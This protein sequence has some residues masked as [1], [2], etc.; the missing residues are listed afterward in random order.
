MLDTLF[1]LSINLTYWLQGLGPWLTPVMRFFTFLGNEEFYLFVMPVIAWVIDYDLGVRV[2]VMLLLTSN[3]NE[4]L[5]LSF[6]MPRPYWVNPEIGNV[7]SPAGG[8]GFPSGHAQNSAAIFGIMAATLKKKW[9]TVVVIFTVFMI[10][11]SR[12]Y[13]G[14]HF[15]AD[16]L[17]GWLVGGL[18]LWIFLKLYSP[19]KEWFAKQTI[20][21]KIA[22]AFIL[23]LV[24]IAITALILAVPSNYQVPAEWLANAHTA[25]PEEELDPF[26]IKNSITTS[27]TLF[28]LMTG[29]IWTQTSGGFAAHRGAWWK[30]VLRF[31]VGIIGMVVIW[32]G[33]DLLFPDNGDLLSYLLRY[34]RYGLVGLWASGGAV[35]TFIKLRLAERAD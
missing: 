28:G 14:E 4:M 8:Y 19:V 33:L 31:L 30:R 2:G 10:G 35:W 17:G 29:I 20:A 34:L 15:L 21:R 1:D 27:A 7:A 23:S 18:I 32:L 22:T 9:F 6:R 25:Y 12:I 5:K 16:V 26:T 3:L 11:L 13:L 24:L